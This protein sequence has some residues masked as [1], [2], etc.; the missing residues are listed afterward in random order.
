MFKKI[1]I[2]LIAI[3]LVFLVWF[4]RDFFREKLFKSKEVVI[5][6]ENTQ[7]NQTEIKKQETSGLKFKEDQIIAQGQIKTAKLK[8]DRKIIYFNQNNFLE[9]DLKGVQKSSLASYPFK[10]LNNIECVSSGN[11]CLIEEE[12]GFFV[13]NV[14][15]KENKPLE[16]KIK[17]VDFN[18]QQD[19]LVYL[20]EE[21]DGYQLSSSN[22]NGENWLQLKKI[23]GDNLKISVSPAE[24]KIVY[25]PQNA[26]EKQAG[27]FLT[28]LIGANS[29]EKIVSKDII[30]LSWSPNGDA[31]LFSF[32]DH[33]V[34]PKRV[35]LG[36]Y[37]LN[38]NQEYSLGLPGI[39]KKCI[40][41]KD[42]SEIYC[43]ILANTEQKS[44]NLTDW[45]ARE[46][47]S[48]DFFWKINLETGEKER[49]FI[50][51]EE[52][53]PVV[54]AFNLFIINEELFFID[55]IS[56]NLIKRNL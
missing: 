9:T 29:G 55:K 10:G 51:E 5:E 33:L 12:G 32:Y 4:F 16:E 17:A 11:Y 26:E 23:K 44:F 25:F 39:A 7:E 49:L 1:L 46:F 20:Y 50:S 35:N 14:N 19:G 48:S 15:E 56:G 3:S 45:Y 31:I 6:T 37:D 22:L 40:W 47:I 27:I 38:N 36:Y 8:D 41:K 24:N 21:K 53:Y 42:S 28:D 13:F 52:K 54:D 30:D 43:G 18:Y 34:T 2:L